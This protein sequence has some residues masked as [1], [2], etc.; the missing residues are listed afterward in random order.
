MKKGYS[1]KMISNPDNKAE[2][3]TALVCVRECNVP[4]VGSWKVNEEISDP[5]II[6]KIVGNTH[7]FKPKEA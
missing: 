4:G 6:E 3:P 7:C 2:L 1:D 5:A